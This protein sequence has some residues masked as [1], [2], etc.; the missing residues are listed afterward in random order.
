MKKSTLVLGLLTVALLV[1]PQFLKNYGIS[2]LS[3]Q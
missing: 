1:A 2:L 3:G